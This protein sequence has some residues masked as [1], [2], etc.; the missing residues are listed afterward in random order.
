MTQAERAER[1]NQWIDKL[2]DKL[3]YIQTVDYTRKEMRL[4]LAEWKRVTIKILRKD[5]VSLR[6]DDLTKT[7][8]AVISGSS[9]E[10]IRAKVYRMNL[11]RLKQQVV[12]DPGRVL[13]GH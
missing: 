13:K 1:V 9:D 3:E 4:E 6:V 11:L 7:T 5:F 2:L 8:Q 12:K 10:D